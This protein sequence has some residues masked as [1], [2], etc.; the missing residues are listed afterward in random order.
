MGHQNLP[1]LWQNPPGASEAAVEDA[2]PSAQ[3]PA[4][5]PCRAEPA[6]TGS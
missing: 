1:V 2:L 3:E 5:C 6:S 4:P